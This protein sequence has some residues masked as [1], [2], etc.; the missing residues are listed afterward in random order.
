MGQIRKVDVPAGSLLA[1]FG[2]AGAYRDCFCQEIDGPA[3][4]EQFVEHFYSSWAFTPE[5][6]A[7]AVIDRGASTEDARRLAYGETD[8]FAMWKV[9]ERRQHELLLQ[10]FRGATATWLSVQPGEVTFPDG[11]DADDP[12][13]RMVRQTHTRL[14]FGSW[15][16]RP[17]RRV[18]KALM[19]FHR[20][21]SR[22]LLAG[23]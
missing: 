11:D 19:P 4:L 12:Q 5:R 21:Y 13:G 1:Q 18:V 22:M 9:V 14:L 8:I 16:G 17:E 15:V 3:T 6:I 23:V 20:W 2:P 10:D 7:L